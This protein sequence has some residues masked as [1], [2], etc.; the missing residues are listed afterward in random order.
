MAGF[1]AG[2]PRSGSCGTGCCQHRSPCCS[3][4]PRSYQHSSLEPVWV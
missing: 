1:D 2:S 3:L 4:R